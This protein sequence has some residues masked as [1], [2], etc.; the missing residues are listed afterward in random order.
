MPAL[1]RCELE[2]AGEAIFPRRPHA[3]GSHPDQ[4]GL[5]LGPVRFSCFSV[6]ACA[7]QYAWARSTRVET[8]TVLPAG[9]LGAGGWRGSGARGAGW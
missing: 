6:L 2:P 5:H 3:D 7:L 8:D 4:L 9:S 1:L